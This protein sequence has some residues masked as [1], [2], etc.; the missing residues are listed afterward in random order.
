MQPHSAPAREFYI[1]QLFK[2]SLRFAEQLEPDAIFILSAQHDLLGLDEVIDE[3]VLTINTM[4]AQ[5]LKRW[6]GKVR[7]RLA[8]VGNLSSDHFIFLAG[9]QYWRYIV[10]YLG[11]Y[12]VPLDGLRTGERIEFLN[13]MTSSRDGVDTRHYEFYDTYGGSY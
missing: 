2:L 8:E 7:S 6:A 3:E 4:K 13:W 5:A 1:G 9:R 10:P 11:S 12:S